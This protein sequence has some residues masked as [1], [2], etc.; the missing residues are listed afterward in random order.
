MKATGYTLRVNGEVIGTYATRMDA[1][2]AYVRD[3]DG[4]TARIEHAGRVERVHHGL[5]RD[6]NFCA[7]TDRSARANEV[8][9]IS[10]DGELR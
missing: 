10:E 9:R 3:C 2:I 1:L 7:W 4:G 5:D 8:A 6:W